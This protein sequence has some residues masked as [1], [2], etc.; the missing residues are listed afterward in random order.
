MCTNEK[1]NEKRKKVWMWKV[2]N[3]LKGKKK[4]REKKKERK[5][6]EKKE[7]RENFSVVQYDYW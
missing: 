2:Y 3:P 6:W 7:E 1:Y 4:N 5:E